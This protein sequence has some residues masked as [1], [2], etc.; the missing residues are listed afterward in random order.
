MFKKIPWFQGIEKKQ[1]LTQE[2]VPSRLLQRV[3]P[4][5]IWAFS[6]ILLSGR[7]TRN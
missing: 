2:K 1:K 5:F 7:N 6:L 3:I 4:V